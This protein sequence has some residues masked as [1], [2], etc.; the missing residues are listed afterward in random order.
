MYSLPKHVLFRD[1]DPFGH[2]H[3]I[4]WGFTKHSYTPE[5]F[6][7]LQPLLCAEI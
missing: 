6:I 2:T 1:R 4:P 5:Q 3:I 7:A